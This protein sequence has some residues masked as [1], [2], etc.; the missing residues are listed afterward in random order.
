[1]REIIKLIKKQSSYIYGKLN[2]CNAMMSIR[3]PINKNTLSD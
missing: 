1:V 2:Y 3:F